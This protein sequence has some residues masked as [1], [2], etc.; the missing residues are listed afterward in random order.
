M[1]SFEGNPVNK[2]AAELAPHDPDANKM[3]D[4]S[5][6]VVI[7]LEDPQEALADFQAGLS[8]QL[9][10]S[11]TMAE[12]SLARALAME[13]SMRAMEMKCQ[14]PTLTDS[15][16]LAFEREFE[17]MVGEHALLLEEASKFI[18]ENA[19][20][21]GASGASSAFWSGWS[22]PFSWPFRC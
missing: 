18:D 19:M 6:V 22:S 10:P 20:G 15:Q 8:E 1:F 21:G 2:H 11:L 3:D 16:R 12:E 7:E 14:D 17:V 13:D 9:A 4:M 5:G